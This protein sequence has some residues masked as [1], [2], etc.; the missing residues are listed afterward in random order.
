MTHS[1]LELSLTRIDLFYFKITL[2]SKKLFDWI[3][4]NISPINI[5]HIREICQNNVRLFWGSTC[6]NRHSESV[7]VIMLTDA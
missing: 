5:I 4:T 7:Q 1:G 2:W 3:I 6:T